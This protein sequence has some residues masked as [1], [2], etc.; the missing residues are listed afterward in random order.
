MTSD[1]EARRVWEVGT[2]AG[3]LRVASQRRDWSRK[4]GMGAPQS[5]QPRHQAGRA[6][7]GVDSGKSSQHLSAR[8]SEFTHGV[9]S[10]RKAVK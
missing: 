7:G 4:N 9:P 3:V 8:G 5:R 6:A 2:I 10:L 1:R